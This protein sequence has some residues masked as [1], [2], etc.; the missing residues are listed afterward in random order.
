[1]HFL[2]IIK[3]I[4]QV[5]RGHI[6]TQKKGAWRQGHCDGV[7]LVQPTPGDAME[8]GHVPERVMCQRSLT[9][10][11]P[12]GAPQDFPSLVLSMLAP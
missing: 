6:H 3:V 10:H 12:S 2:A 4:L 5:C 7:Q 1:M 11:F 8:E 9:C